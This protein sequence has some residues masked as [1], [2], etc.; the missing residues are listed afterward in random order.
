[1]RSSAA[2]SSPARRRELSARLPWGLHSWGPTMA[3]CRRRLLVLKRCPGVPV[4]TSGSTVTW[5]TALIRPAWVVHR[6]TPTAP[7]SGACRALWLTR[8]PPNQG[9]APWPSKPRFEPRT[10]QGSRL[11]TSFGDKF[12]RREAT[13]AR[14]P[15]KEEGHLLA[16][17]EALLRTRTADPLLTVEVS[18]RG[19]GS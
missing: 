12:G 19:R 16:F 14:C 10:R 4:E 9:G 1:M 13:I 15:T 11:G 7:R 18:A 5:R 17:C 2:P 8:A 3:K 6:R